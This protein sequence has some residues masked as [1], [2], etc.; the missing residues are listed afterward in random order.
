MFDN[1]D[2]QGVHWRFAY[3]KMKFSHEGNILNEKKNI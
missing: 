1:D 2:L 3:K